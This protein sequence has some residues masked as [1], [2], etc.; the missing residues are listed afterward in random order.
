MEI[1]DPVSFLQ[2]NRKR[3]LYVGFL[4][5]ASEAWFPLCMVSNS[6]EGSKLDTLFVSSSYQEMIH[7]VEDYA[8]EIP[9]VVQTFVLYL[10]PEEIENVIERY[11][12]DKMAIVLPEGGGEGCGCGCDCH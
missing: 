11:A 5:S 1:V 10:M 8:K 7:V 2:N 12:L 6:E 3:M 9:Q 4:K